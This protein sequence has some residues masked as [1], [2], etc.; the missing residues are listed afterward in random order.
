MTNL[1]ETFHGVCDEH[2]RFLRGHFA[3]RW[4]AYHDAVLHARRKGNHAIRIGGRSYSD[5]SI[6]ALETETLHERGF[7]QSLRD[8]ILQTSGKLVL[9]EN[10]RE[11]V[12]SI[13][14]LDQI[15]AELERRGSTPRRGYE[16]TTD[17]LPKL[18][19]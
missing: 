5:Q 9:E 1:G 4:Q 10:E 19:R 7:L 14:R 15:R 13:D 6:D 16:P 18:W 8:P 3:T 2:P 11:R 17:P 12:A